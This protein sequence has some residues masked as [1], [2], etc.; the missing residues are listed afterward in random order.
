MVHPWASNDRKLSYSGHNCWVF[1]K[2]ECGELEWSAEKQKTNEKKL[3]ENLHESF[4]CTC[5]LRVTFYGNLFH[6]LQLIK[7]SE[8]S[9]KEE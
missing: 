3:T 1:F 9:S 8:N 4:Y 6:I 5:S 7:L 2:W